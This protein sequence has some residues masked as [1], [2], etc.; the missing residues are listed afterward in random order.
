MRWMWLAAVAAGW[1]QVKVQV[2]DAATQEPVVHARVVAIDVEHGRPPVELLTGDLGTVEFKGLPVGRYMVHVSKAGY[3]R[4]HSGRQLAIPASGKAGMEPVLL[5]R[6]AVISGRVLDADGEPMEHVMVGAVRPDG[7]RRGLNF[8]T[9]T[10]DRGIF[11]I[12]RIP[13]GTYVVVAV[14]ND[15][16]MGANVSVQT[17][18]PNGSDAEQAAPVT[19]RAGEQREGID[20][21]MQRRTAVMVSGRVTNWPAQGGHGSVQLSP[22]RGGALARQ[23]SGSIFPDGRFTAASILAGEYTLRAV[24]HGERSLQAV[25]QR[26]IS[27]GDT[28]VED[29]NVELKPLLTVNVKVRR[30]DRSAKPLT[31]RRV[32]I[33]SVESE[34]GAGNDGGIEQDGTVRIEGIEPGQNRVLASLPDGE[35]IQTVIANGQVRPGMDLDF[36]G[37]AVPVEIVIGNQP[38]K[39]TG[40][41]EG[42]GPS[43]SVLLIP[44]GVD[45]ERLLRQESFT[46]QV[47]NGEFEV[48]NVRPGKYH[49][50]AVP[51]FDVD[52]REIWPKMKD[53]STAIVVEKNGTTPAKLKLQK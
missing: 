12:A 36:S 5:E 1:S 16:E 33:S 51:V 20:I 24:L 50:L 39:V 45:N 31:G 21:R 8:E 27:V 19:L 35:Y 49:V 41:V 38:G 48:S 28:P 22:V 11:R 25:G 23:Y 18:Y 43:P 42:E 37:G 6:Q 13:P 46:M 15:A 14:P 10:D 17:F 7:S 26:K 4:F 9:Q 53:R 30:E 3:L 29:A 44:D 40:T 34:H 2:S 47:V 52:V 32:G